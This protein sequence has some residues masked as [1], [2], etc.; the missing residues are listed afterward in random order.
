MLECVRRDARLRAQWLGT[1]EKW[2]AF[3]CL[4]ATYIQESAV[5]PPEANRALVH[6]LSALVGR[7]QM[8]RF[9]NEARNAT[10]E[11]LRRRVASA[12]PVPV[13]R[14]QIPGRW[15]SLVDAAGRGAMPIHGLQARLEG[16]GGVGVYSGATKTFVRAVGGVSV[17]VER[18]EERN[19]AAQEALAALYGHHFAH[20]PTMG[21]YELIFHMMML[22]LASACDAGT[23]RWFDL[24]TLRSSVRWIF[25]DTTRTSLSDLRR[26]AL[27]REVRVR[28]GAVVEPRW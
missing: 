23:V 27:P 22:K 2:N 17:L 7:E 6:G 15:V 16:Q 11:A 19:G 3:E 18:D 14:V 8:D 25:L 20:P 21:E 10:R 9:L 24:D 5:H 13:V 12:G 26:V 28:V 4:F 1:P